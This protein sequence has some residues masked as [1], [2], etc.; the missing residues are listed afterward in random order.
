MEGRMPNL[1]PLLKVQEALLAGQLTQKQV[2]YVNEKTKGQYL[3]I[4]EHCLDSFSKFNESQTPSNFYANTLCAAS[5]VCPTELNDFSNCISARIPFIQ[6]TK[7]G[8]IPDHA[9]KSC[10]RMR[11]SLERCAAHFAAEVTSE[12]VNSL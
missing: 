11:Q 12:T 10:Q 5:V 8:N 4:V 7:S 9:A 6:A 2:E 3:A 1:T